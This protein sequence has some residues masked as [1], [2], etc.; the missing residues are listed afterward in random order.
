MVI[1]IIFV[2]C[3]GVMLMDDPAPN[4]PQPRLVQTHIE[5]ASPYAGWRLYFPEEGN[6]V[7]QGRVARQ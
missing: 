6:V 1:V 4:R 7:I 2:L 3:A 5:V